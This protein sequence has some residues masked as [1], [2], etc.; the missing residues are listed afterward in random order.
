[1]AIDFEDEYASLR[2]EMLEGFERIHDTGKYG[3]GAFIAFLAYYY[4][5]HNFSN[6]LALVVFQLLV[7]LMGVY[8]RRVYQSIYVVGTYIAFVIEKTNGVRW[9]RMSR[10]IGEFKENSGEQDVEK[11]SSTKAPKG[12]GKDSFWFGLL[13]LALI[14]VGI[15]A[16]LLKA[17]VLSL[18]ASQQLLY[19]LIIVALL[20]INLYIFYVLSWGMGKF[21]VKEEQKWKAYNKVFGKP[22]WRDP[23]VDP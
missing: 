2:Q 1:M 17:S 16:V 13:L 14:F 19:I 18:C 4:E 8:A 3:I 5:S 15:V 20:I 21:R 10:S 11:N 9:H 7:L 12:W 22:K 23:Y 6:F